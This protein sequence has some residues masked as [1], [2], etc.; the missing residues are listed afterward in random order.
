MKGQEPESQTNLL[1]AIVLSMAIML[2]WQYF[3]AGPSLERQAEQQAAQTGNGELPNGLSPSGSTAGNTA[4]SASPSGELT[5]PVALAPK[6]RQAA[7]SESK[8]LTVDTPSLKGSIA[9]KGALIDDL[10]LKN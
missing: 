6:T 5:A 1:V 9:L 3:Y 10:I 7:L 2:G 4:P 8:R